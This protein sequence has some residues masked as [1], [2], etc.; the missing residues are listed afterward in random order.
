MRVQ[1]QVTQIPVEIQILP[2]DYFGGHVEIHHG[3]SVRRCEQIKKQTGKDAR[4]VEP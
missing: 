4:K 3:K 2:I 1:D